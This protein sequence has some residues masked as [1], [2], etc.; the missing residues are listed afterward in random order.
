MNLGLGLV[1]YGAGQKS[2][3]ANYKAVMV[4]VKVTRPGD[5]I[6]PLCPYSDAKTAV[7]FWPF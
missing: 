3:L 6:C 5:L 4:K 2:K 7:C 1:Y